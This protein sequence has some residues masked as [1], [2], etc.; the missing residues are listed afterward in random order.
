MSTGIC[1]AVL[2]IAWNALEF[3]SFRLIQPTKKKRESNP[4]R[5]VFG[6]IFLHDSHH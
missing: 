3:L 4:R 5:I 1:A 6:S 2:A